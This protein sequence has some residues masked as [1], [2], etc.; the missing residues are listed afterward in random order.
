MAVAALKN[1]R[2]GKLARD[3][4]VLSVGLGLR[5]V[6]QAGVF[7]IIARL[8]G[9]EGYGAFSA[10]LALAGA[11]G[12]FVGLGGQAILIRDVARDPARFAQSFA[13]SLA[14]LGL[15]LP[16]IGGFYVLSAH[17]LLPELPWP[18][19]A[20]VGLGELVFLPLVNLVACAYQ[21]FERMGRS[22]RIQLAPVLTRLAGAGLLVA[23]AFRFGGTDDLLLGWAGLYAAASGLAAWYVIA[24]ARRDLGGPVW[25]GWRSLRE[26]LR[27]G[28]PFAFLGSAHKLYVDADKFLLAN[29]S[30]LET[31]GMYSAG[32]RFV[33]LAF[34]P[35]Y[36]L[37]SAAAPRLFRAGAGGTAGAL[38]GV[39]SLALPALGYCLTVAV[40]LTL[41]AP[42]LPWLLGRDYEDAMTV[43]RWLAWLPLASLPKL[44]L[45]YALATSDAQ[46]RC[47]AALLGGALLN[48]GLNVWW[49][50][51]WGWQGAAL[52][53][54]VAEGAMA[55]LLLGLMI[56][57]EKK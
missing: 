51:L 47:M 16:P 28:V 34:L 18:L 50:P 55:V 2:P 17:W 27:A 52:A 3:T 4:V 14:I 29:L 9:S 31:A 54:F 6:A 32:Y 30:T 7:L 1:Y 39:T 21:G 38:K 44:L 42:Y 10:A 13:A 37:L 23:A 36:S 35:L 45:H 26:H 20:G 8:L 46:M 12:C 19:L 5:A 24:V 41:L 11:W 56:W 57:S 48:A 53:T 33:D 22:A 15:S 25:A 43:V 49:I 40:G